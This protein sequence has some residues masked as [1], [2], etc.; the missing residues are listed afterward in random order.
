[1]LGAVVVLLAGAAVV[2]LLAPDRL[3]LADRTPL[4]Q[5]VALRGLV[6][7]L[8]VVG[9]VLLLGAVAGWRRIADRARLRVPGWRLPVALAAVLVLGAAAQVAVLVGRGL[10][11]AGSGARPG[12]AADG[13]LVVLSFNTFGVVDADDLTALVQR[14]DAD[15]VVLAETSGSTA[16]AVAR[17]LTAAGRP[18][19]ALAADSASARVEGVA[20]LVRDSLGAYAP[21][22]A[23][24]PATELGTFAAVRH[25]DASTAHTAYPT[26][27]DTLPDRAHTVYSSAGDTLPHDAHTAYPTAGE[28]HADA[29]DTAPAPAPGVVVAAHTR[30]PSAASSMPD[31]RAHAAGIAEVCRS[32]PGAIVAGDL[33]STLDHPGLDD[34]GPCV[35]AAAEAGAAGLGTWPADVPRVLAAPIDHVLVDGRAWRVTAFGVLDRVGASDHRPVVAHLAPR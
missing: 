2:V 31:W 26:A 23:G 19:T 20:L 30:A 5:L 33:N 14:Q 21:T 27:G 3:D 4:A 35:D 8:L 25:D 6:A 22:S 16:R 24:L 12:P 1:V 18:T 10:D 29:A 34:L 15:L 28:A 17:A 13:E 9:A 11:G 7:T 32:T